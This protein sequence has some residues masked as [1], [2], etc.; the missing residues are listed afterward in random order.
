MLLC[1]KR[2]G[3]PR[4]KLA[5][6]LSETHLSQDFTQ[7]Y[8]NELED[9]GR[10]INLHICPRAKAVALTMEVIFIFTVA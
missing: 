1:R 2:D 9:I 7:L 10:I 5:V 3:A 4:A 6:L 8:A